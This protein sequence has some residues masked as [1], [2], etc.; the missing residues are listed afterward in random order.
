M[1]TD[2]KYELLCYRKNNL[3]LIKYIARRARYWRQRC[4]TEGLLAMGSRMVVSSAVHSE[5][6]FILK[7]LTGTYRSTKK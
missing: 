7:D 3:L 5:L 2:Y 4:P 1:K 6:I